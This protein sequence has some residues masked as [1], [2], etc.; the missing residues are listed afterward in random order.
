MAR[1][2]RL[3]YP[4]AVYHVTA[5]GNDRGAIFHTVED[6]KHLL[7]LLSAM[8]A[9]HAVV[10]HA[11]VLMDNHFHLVVR[12][13]QGNLSRFMHDVNTG[14]SVWTN[15]RNRRT[16]HVFEGRFKAIVMA[17]EGYLRSVSAYVHLNPV[18]VRG[19][20]GRSV[21]ERLDRLTKYPW[22]SYPAYTR[23]VPAARQPAVTPDPVWGD[24]GAR[25]EREGR[26]LYRE[27]VQGWLIEESASPLAEVKRGCYLGGDDFA[28]RME[29]LLVGDK[30]ISDQVVAYK[31]WRRSLPTPELMSRI[32][33]LWGVPPAE[34][35]SRRRPNEGR[36]VVIYLCREA[37]GK[38][39]KEIGQ[40]LGIKAAAVSLA[41]K[42]VRE[43]LATHP[44]LRKRVAAV[45]DEVIKLS[46]T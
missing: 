46:K 31:E 20:K 35:H 45:K 18:R 34:L 42:R 5:R 13:P 6:R 40:V 26:R 33:E 19:W 1:H 8:M 22:S 9:R 43:R 14:F 7:E 28:E 10:L 2:L 16:G 11:Y 30:P 24:L 17:E 25:T 44:R 15:K 37:G 39:L 3:E 29:Q 41:A 38:E 21:A 27:Y 23:R 12:T 32:G 4:G 36:D